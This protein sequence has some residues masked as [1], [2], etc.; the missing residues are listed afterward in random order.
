M[1][2]RI[3]NRR[4]A[5]TKHKGQ[6]RDNFYR[7]DV[8]AGVS[9]RGRLYH[10]GEPLSMNMYTLIIIGLVMGLTVTEIA[11]HPQLCV[12]RCTVYRCLHRFAQTNSF[13]PRAKGAC[14]EE[15]GK[16]KLGKLEKLFI[17]LYLIQ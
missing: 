8:P 12:D 2:H 13:R 6:L 1:V 10:K 7:L 17:K 4:D 15:N 3:D 14:G 9:K 5:R 11:R 16:I